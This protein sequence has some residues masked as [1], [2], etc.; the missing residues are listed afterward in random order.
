MSSAIISSMDRDARTKEG[1]V[2]FNIPLLPIHVELRR[3]PLRPPRFTIR[4]LMIV[5]VMAGVFFSLIAWLERLNQRMNYHI[6]QITMVNGWSQGRA[7]GITPL[8]AWHRTK[9]TE[10]QTVRDRVELAA[11]VLLL[12]SVSIGLVAALGRVI[13]STSRPSVIPPEAEQSPPSALMCDE[14]PGRRT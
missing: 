5:V 10:Y 9:M 3:R 14:R 4:G 6:D 2:R 1:V 8:E 7:P 11:F 12:A 13:Q